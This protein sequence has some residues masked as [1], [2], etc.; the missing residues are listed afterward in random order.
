MDA[1]RIDP[2]IMH[3]VPCFAG[4]RVRV[5]SLFDYLAAGR[6]IDLFLEHFPTVEREQVQAV[7]AMSR[8]MVPKMA[9]GAA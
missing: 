4:T 9:L 6:T 2:D 5:K 7:L 3:G 1:V 8:E